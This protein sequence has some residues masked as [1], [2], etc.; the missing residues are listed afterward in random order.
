[1]GVTQHGARTPTRESQ[2]VTE[3]AED[4]GIYAALDTKNYVI[5][6]T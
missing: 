3:Q 1:M 6:V 4:F 2:G 5:G